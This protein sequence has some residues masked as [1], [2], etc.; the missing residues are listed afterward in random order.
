MFPE[1]PV[2]ACSLNWSPPRPAPCSFWKTSP[3]EV[4]IVCTPDI[5]IG[6]AGAPPLSSSLGPPGLQ[7]MS[8]GLLGFLTASAADYL[9]AV[10]G[11]TPRS[12][13]TYHRRQFSAPGNTQLRVDPVQH[14]VDRPDRDDQAVRD[15]A[16]R[17]ARRHE[18]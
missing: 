3:D 4:V 8:S 13:R 9:W 14:V 10:A 6:E 18:P 17:Q 11:T 1:P 15:R 12:E 2:A 7:V 5:R 16:A